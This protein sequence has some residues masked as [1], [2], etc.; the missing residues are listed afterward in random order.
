MSMEHKVQFYQV[1]DPISFEISSR[2]GHLGRIVG[3]KLVNYSYRTFIVEFS[4][5]SRLWLLPEEI[6]SVKK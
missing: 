5:N 2:V 6:R 1:K 3:I 4:D